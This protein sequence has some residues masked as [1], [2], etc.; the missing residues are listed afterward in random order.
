M[1]RREGC[2]RCACPS[3]R[4]HCVWGLGLRVDHLVFLR[5]VGYDGRAALSL[6]SSLTALA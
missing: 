2:R 6:F 3:D 4:G 5:N 1:A